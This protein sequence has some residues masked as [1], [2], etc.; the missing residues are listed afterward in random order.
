MLSSF[1]WIASWENWFFFFFPDEWGKQNMIGLEEA[2]GDMTSLCNLDSVNWEKKTQCG[3]CELNFIWSKTWALAQ[4]TASQRAL[5]NCSGG[6]VSI[7][8]ILVKGDMGSQAHILVE[9][10]S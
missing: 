1:V 10:F 4:E 7:D 3:G 9:V 5:R 2:R 6:K 8:V